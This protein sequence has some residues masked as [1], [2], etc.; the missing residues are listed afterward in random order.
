MN[1]T[2]KRIALGKWHVLV[3]DRLIREEKTKREAQE[4]VKFLA[5][6]GVFIDGTDCDFSCVDEPDSSSANAQPAKKLPGTSQD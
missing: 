5:R 2:I 1:A 6:A 3:G 4:F